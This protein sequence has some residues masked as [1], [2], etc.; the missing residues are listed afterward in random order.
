[1]LRLQ[2][3]G[4]EAEVERD[5]GE[6]RKSYC[7]GTFKGHDILGV[8]QGG[9]TIPLYLVKPKVLMNTFQKS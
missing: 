3:E 1:M 7:R 8:G 2:A 6:R 4:R 9:G 5:I